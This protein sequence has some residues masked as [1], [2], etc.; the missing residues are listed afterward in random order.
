M[1]L[2]L[3]VPST[4][5]PIS[6]SI[7]IQH[8]SWL[9]SNEQINFHQIYEIK[10]KLLRALPEENSKYF[11]NEVFLHPKN[12][13][14]QDFLWHKND[15]MSGIY[16]LVHGVVEEWKLDSYD[17]DAYYCEL[18]S[19]ENHMRQT[20][21]TKQRISSPSNSEYHQFLSKSEVD[22][23]YSS[24][25]ENETNKQNQDFRSSSI[26]NGKYRI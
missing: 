17:I 26:F 7:V 5:P 19:K 9:F 22:L 3:H 2:D 16:L 20:T 18:H 12:F 4:M 23:T 1:Y 21:L 10:Q 14:W 8:L 6:S 25:R 11:S 24:V 15:T 13:S